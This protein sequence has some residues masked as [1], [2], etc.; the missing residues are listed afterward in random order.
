[1]S[2]LLD[3]YLYAVAEALPGD[4][5]K[6]DVVAEIRDELQS[7]IDE[8]KDEVAVIKAYGRPQVVA[9]RYGGVQYLVGPDLFPFYWA[10]LR[11]VLAGG[12]ALVLVGGGLMAIVAHDGGIFFATLGVAWNTAL[13]IVAVVLFIAWVAGFG[14]RSGSGARWYRW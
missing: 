8:G 3:R 9:A 10:T 11:N 4:V 7:Q 2:T 6:D 5:A 14:F 1:M 12:V 13:W